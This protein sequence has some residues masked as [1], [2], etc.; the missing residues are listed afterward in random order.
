MKTLAQAPQPQRHQT[1]PQDSLQLRAG[2]PFPLPG[3]PG[4]PGPHPMPEEGA[5]TILPQDSRKSRTAEVLEMGRPGF[6]LSL[7]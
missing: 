7:R 4:L 3:C 6:A 1:R 2:S 5:L